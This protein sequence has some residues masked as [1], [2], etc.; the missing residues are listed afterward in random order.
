MSEKIYTLINKQTNTLL[1]NLIEHNTA[2]TAQIKI[3]KK[4]SDFK[5][6]LPHTYYKKIFI[7]TAEINKM[8]ETCIYCNLSPWNI[9]FFYFQCFL[10]SMPKFNLLPCSSLN[11]LIQLKEAVKQMKF[12][13]YIKWQSWQ[14]FSKALCQKCPNT[15]FFLVCI[16]LCSD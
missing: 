14:D 13:Q 11:L 8:T 16:F 2:N 12:W 9:P 5:T 10:L 4:F 7:K 1:N 15:E 6:L 3:V